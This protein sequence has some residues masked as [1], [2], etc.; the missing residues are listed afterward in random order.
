MT[1]ILMASGFSKRFGGANKLLYPFRG[2]ALVLYTLELV[3][4]GGLF[5]NIFFVTAFDAAAA[6]A[7]R[8]KGITIIRNA[9]PERGQ[10]ESIRLGVEA[11][12]KTVDFEDGHYIFFPCDQPF[13][14]GESLQLILNARRRSHIVQPFYRGEKGSPVLFSR[15]FG[16]ELAA[17]AP[18]EHGRDIIKKYPDKLI[19]VDTPPR[20]GPSPL[21]DIDD[22]EM[23]A[24]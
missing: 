1:A 2:K 21:T 17:L 14:D 18:G 19:R 5:E 24:R 16:A 12:E 10:R 20:E 7:A 6:L 8:F 15:T 4:A 11:A 3:S 22:P 13:L 23:L 9:N